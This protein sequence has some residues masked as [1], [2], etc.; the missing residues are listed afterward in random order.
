[1]SEEKRLEQIVN[2]EKI[3]KSTEQSMVEKSLD[4]TKF[5]KL[6]SE[7]PQST[8]VTKDDNNTVTDSV[9]STYQPVI[10]DS[11]IIHKNIENVLSEGMENVYLSL[12]AG[13]QRIFKIK[14]EEI[15]A[16]ITTLILQAKVKVKEITELILEWLRIIPKVNK[17]YLEQ[18]AKIKTEKILNINKIKQK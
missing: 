1:M 15:S 5:E 18:E 6:S 4:S 14:G 8:K 10:N 9:S 13:T 11:A 2:A 7:K 16:K 3:D 17:H 12:D